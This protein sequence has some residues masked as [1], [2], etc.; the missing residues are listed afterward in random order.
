MDKP[1]YSLTSGDIYKFFNGKVKILTFKDIAKY[2]TLEELL[3]PY[4]RVVILF[5]RSKGVG[6]WTS[7]HKN[8]AGDIY[9]FDSY[10]IKPENQLKYSA[11]KNRYL[12][13]RQKTLLR[14]FDGHTVKYN[15]V[16]LQAWKKGIST[17]GRWV[18]SRLSCDHL[19]SYEFADLIKSQTDNP[20]QFI[21]DATNNFLLD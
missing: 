17:C 4:N 14:L 16:A 1:S 9:F 13:Q 6:H 21:T 18:I 5:E 15:P 8:R 11:G 19:N 10:S 3:Y 20:D 7:L 12:K 2:D